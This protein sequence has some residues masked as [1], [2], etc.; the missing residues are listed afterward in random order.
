MSS[1]NGQRNAIDR[2]HG[3]SPVA[4]ATP[5]SCATAH[6]GRAPQRYSL[7]YL[8]LFGVSPPAL[9]HIAADAGYDFISLRPIYMGLP[10][11]ANFDLSANPPLM[12]E[13]RAALADTGLRVHDIELARIHDG[14]DPRT[15]LP[16]MEAGAALGATHLISSIWTDDRVFATECYAQLCDLALPL[17]MTVDLE[18]VTFSSVRTLGE[19]LDVLRGARRE[20][21]GVLIDMLHFARSLGVP[22]DLDVVPREWFHFTH[23]CDAPAGIPETREGLVHTAR[24][25]RLYIGEGGLD[26]AG[27][28]AH[29]PEVTHSVELPHTARVRELGAAEHA[30]RCL[31]SAR[32]F[33]DARRAS[34]RAH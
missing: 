20:N 22:G 11:E 3:P 29:L 19:V 1:E 34:Q 18:M 16:A 26:V 28:L 23:L 13:T 15:Y 25:E 4:P 12:A 2:G 30:R 9:A 5:P 32:A 10:G 6:E 8:T 14:L 31:Q 24:D 17:G 21:C 33:I 7:A 27:I